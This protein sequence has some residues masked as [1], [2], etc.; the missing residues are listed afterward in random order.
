MKRMNIIIA[1]LILLISSCQQPEIKEETPECIEQ[2]I[3]EN[4]NNQT[5]CESGKS[6][7]RYLFNDRYVYFFNPGDCGADMMADVYDENCDR[8]CGLGGIA[9][10][11]ICEDV[12]FWEKASDETLIWED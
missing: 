10:N 6:V 11:L 4:K 12:N 1:I 9:G 8:I 3:Q 7:Y 2:K 5:S